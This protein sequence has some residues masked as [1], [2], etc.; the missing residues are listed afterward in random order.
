MPSH[1]IEVEIPVGS[2]VRI[3]VPAQQ[4]EQ[5]IAA[6]QTHFRAREAVEAAYLGM[7]EVS[8]PNGAPYFTF[9]VGIRCEA[10]G[11]AAEERAALDVLV[12]VPLEQ[13][14]ISVLPLTDAYFTH[15]AFRFYER[16]LHPKK[17]GLFG[18][19]FG[20]L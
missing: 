18:R 3:G 19:F 9:S 6:L 16:P 1:V 12:N 13:L 15:E 7:M 14:P 8:P 17:P 10:S 2:K 5:A 4:P 20:R 11:L